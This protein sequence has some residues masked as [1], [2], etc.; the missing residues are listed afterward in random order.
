[1]GSVQP[2]AYQKETKVGRVA[3]RPVPDTVV[4]AA[5]YHGLQSLPGSEAGVTGLGLYNTLTARLPAPQDD[6][7]EDDRSR[8]VGA[9]YGI[10]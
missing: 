1:M 7:Q 9:D 10:D 8:V 2:L 3:H 6:R 5:S 4:A